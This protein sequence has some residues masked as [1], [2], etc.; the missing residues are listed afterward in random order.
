MDLLL[1]FKTHAKTDEQRE[2]LNVLVFQSYNFP[3]LFW[4]DYQRLTQL[5]G[6][7]NNNKPTTYVVSTEKLISHLSTIS[8]SP[9]YL[10][11]TQSHATTL[12]RNAAHLLALLTS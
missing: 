8:L 9:F 5:A 7:L 4:D 12:A 1:L 2:A 3:N 10:A 11:V 6:Q